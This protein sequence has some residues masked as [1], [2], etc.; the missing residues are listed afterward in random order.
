VSQGFAATTVDQI[1]TAADV[2][3]RTIFRHFATKEAILFDHLVVRRDAAVKLLHERPPAEPALVSLHAVLREL[4]TQGY[5]RGAL[6]QIRDVLAKNP[7][8]AGQHSAVL[9]AFESNL[10]AAIQG[11]LDDDRSSRLDNYA[12]TLMALSW[13]TGA[14]RIYLLEN[15]SSL[16]KCFDEVV[17]G[18]LRSSADD[19]APSLDASCA[20]DK[21]RAKR[22][23]RTRA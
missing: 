9:L 5:D 22:R 16:V 3:R 2:G 12:L 7:G 18:C 1:A 20:P 21:R 17:A 8:L 6:V 4:C 19:L 23:T 11:R 14:I 13:F 10:S 15:R